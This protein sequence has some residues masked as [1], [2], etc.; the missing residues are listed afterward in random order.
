MRDD[1]GIDESEIVAVRA[2]LTAEQVAALKLPP[3]RV[4][5]KTTSSN[6]AA[7]VRQFVDEVYELEAVPAVKLQRLLT[8]ALESVIDAE[9]FNAEVEAEKRDAE[10]I[11]AAR[12]RI[13]AAI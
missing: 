3:S 7:F 12:R 6:H 13:M 4:K 2:A 10:E 9:L 11:R 1:F 8:E 5:S